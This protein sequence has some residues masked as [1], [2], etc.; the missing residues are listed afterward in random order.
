VRSLTGGLKDSD[1]S[2]KTECYQLERVEVYKA[3]L[4]HYGTCY[5]LI[6]RAVD[7]GPTQE[8]VAEIEENRNQ[9]FEQVQSIYLFS[10]SSVVDAAAILMSQVNFMLKWLRDVVDG[11]DNPPE[12]YRYREKLLNKA[13]DFTEYARKELGVEK[14]DFI[15]HDEEP[16]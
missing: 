13:T 2:V 10:S 8:M 3:F 7:K 6:S 16:K 1:G 11:K 12:M 4:A 14:A 5:D 15:R 9:M